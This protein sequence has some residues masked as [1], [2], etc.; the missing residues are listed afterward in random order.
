MST[1]RETAPHK[2][3]PILVNEILTL[4]QDIPQGVSSYFDGTFGRGGHLKAVLEQFPQARALATDKDSAAVEFAE[5]NFSEEIE[6]K[7]LQILHADYSQILEIINSEKT[8]LKSFD[9]ILLD[10]GISSPQVD[11]AER[12]F[13]FIKDGP[14]DMRMNQKQLVK[15]ADI[16]NGWTEDEL[17]NLFFYLGE[18]KASGRVVRAIVSDRR[19]K[20]FSTTRE[21][22]SLIERVEGWKKKGMHPATQYFMALRIQVN[23]ELDHLPGALKDCMSLLNDGGRLFVISF[24][25]LED[26]IVKKQFLEN[27]ILGFTVNKRIIVPSENEQATNSRSRSAKLR[28]FQRSFEKRAPAGKKDKYAHKKGQ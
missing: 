8:F 23:G 6:N 9:M 1:L 18:V 26:R 14:L 2:H 13:S 10:L 4:A 21:L 24:H 15:A 20:P 19:E 25:S 22:A 17:R 27:E 28:V 5:K 11:E 12:G 3:V 7:R 16:I